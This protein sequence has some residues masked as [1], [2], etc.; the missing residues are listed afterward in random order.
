MEGEGYIR[1]GLREGLLHDNCAVNNAWPRPRVGD[2]ERWKIVHLDS[3]GVNERHAEQGVLTFQLTRRTHAQRSNPLITTRS[4][5]TSNIQTPSPDFDSTSSLCIQRPSPSSHTSNE[6]A[7]NHQHASFPT[8]P[9]TNILKPVGPT[10]LALQPRLPRIKLTGL[11]SPTFRAVG[12]VVEWDVVVADIL[13]PKGVMGGHP[14]QRNDH[15][16]REMFAAGL[17]AGVAGGR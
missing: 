17:G 4:S 13:E 6:L 3:R 12:T 15:V 16:G 5:T 10:I 1:E 14:D 11:T 9:G 7:P 8:S 2:R